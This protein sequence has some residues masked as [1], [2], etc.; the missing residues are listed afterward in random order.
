MH[1]IKKNAIKSASVLLSTL[2]L[3][4]AASRTVVY[5]APTAINVQA[6]SDN[7][8][9]TIPSGYYDSVEI[10]ATSVYKKGL[11]DGK[12]NAAVNLKVN[13]IKVDPGEKGKFTKDNSTSP[14]LFTEQNM[15]DFTLEV[16]PLS[17]WFKLSGWEITFD[18]ESNIVYKASWNSVTNTYT[19]NTTVTIEVSGVYTLSIAGS[20]GQTK[21]EGAGGKGATLSGDFHLEKGGQLQYVINAS[22]VY[23]GGGYSAVNYKKPGSS[24][25]YPLMVAGGGA[26]GFY[27]A[28]GIDGSGNCLDPY[29]SNGSGRVYNGPSSTSLDQTSAYNTGS[30]APSGYGPEW[31][32]VEGNKLIQCRY[33]GGCETFGGGAGWRGGKNGYKQ[34]WEGELDGRPY[35]GISSI[36]YKN[37]AGSSHYITAAEASSW[38][39]TDAYS[40]LSKDGGKQNGSNAHLTFTGGNSTTAK[41]TLALVSED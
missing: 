8:T 41:G 23:G 31:G 11:E 19:S 4:T 9:T 22:S 5:A 40:L 27:I 39:L 3:F 33:E 34:K 10:D 32:Y 20:P 36:K 24:T 15:S 18:D 12:A 2:S 35:S 28:T 37:T 25:F 21:S 29:L 16:S 26:S 14:K 6:G 30:M 7:N 1:N 38:G 17:S 13:N